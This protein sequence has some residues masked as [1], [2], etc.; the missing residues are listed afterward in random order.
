MPKTYDNIN[1]DFLWLWSWYWLSIQ[2]LTYLEKTKSVF[3][4][5]I[6]LLCF[7]LLSILSRIVR[8]IL[9]QKSKQFHQKLYPNS[10]HISDCN[11][12]RTHNDLVR[13]RSLN[14]LAKFG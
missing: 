4:F 11:G 9:S 3:K 13:K 2:A 10:F 7:T 12:T 6:V 8:P 5:Q 1:V 14:H